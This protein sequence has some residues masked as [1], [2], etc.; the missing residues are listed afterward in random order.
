M[1]ARVPLA[2]VGGV[3][4]GIGATLPVAALS[5]LFIG[6]G[7]KIIN[8]SVSSPLEADVLPHPKRTMDFLLEFE[9]PASSVPDIFYLK[10]LE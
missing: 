8:H 10:K 3:S 9:V 6:M 2:A 1:I 5:S 4:S 7:T